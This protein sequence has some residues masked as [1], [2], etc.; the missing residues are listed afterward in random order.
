[1]KMHSVGASV[2][3]PKNDTVD[4]IARVDPETGQTLRLF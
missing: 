2:N 3:S 4:L 1:M